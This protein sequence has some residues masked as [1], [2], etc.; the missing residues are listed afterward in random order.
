[1]DIRLPL[2]QLRPRLIHSND[3][4][5]GNY[6]VTITDANGCEGT[7]S[8]M[9]TEPTPIDFEVTAIAPPCL[10]AVEGQIL[11]QNLVGGVGNYSYSFDGNTFVEV[12][13]DTT[14]LDFIS[15]GEHSIFIV[16]GNGCGFEQN[17]LVPEPVELIL[18]LGDNRPIQLGES[19]DIQPQTNF[20]ATTILW[21]DNVPCDT[22]FSQLVSPINETTYTLELFDENGCF[23]TDEITIFVEKNRNVYIPNAFSPDENGLNDIFFINAGQD[24]AEVKNFRIFNRWGEVVFA[25]ENFQPND[26]TEGWDGF[27]KGE[28]LNP[29]VFVFFAEIEF[30]DGLVKVYKGDVTLTR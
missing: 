22:C 6:E 3:L 8:I 26:A 4:T 1:M 30:K 14:L 12:I 21:S 25:N 9:M 11:F 5:A 27:F 23:V 10:D 28:R 17:I 19:F 13:N 16:D 24:V 29:S 18:E 15:V 2:L 7:A 20:A